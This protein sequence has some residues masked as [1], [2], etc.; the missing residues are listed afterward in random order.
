MNP[1]SLL[2]ALSLLLVQLTPPRALSED[3]P[4]LPVLV[5]DAPA[6]WKP[7]ELNEEMPYRWDEGPVRVLVWEVVDDGERV[8]E[9]CLV[10][11]QY[12]E[13]SKDG[14]A[15]AFG[16]LVRHPKAKKPAWHAMTLWITPDPEFKNPPAIWGYECYKSAPSDKEVAKF[17]GDRGWASEVTPHEAYGIFGGVAQTKMLRPKVTDGGVC[18]AAWKAALGRDPDPKLFPELAVPTDEKRK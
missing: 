11:K 16:Y 14:E 17:L 9:R 3:T 18:R 5:K 6:N 8:M 4:G 1:T 15:F 7:A 13:P 2:A 10:V 12:K